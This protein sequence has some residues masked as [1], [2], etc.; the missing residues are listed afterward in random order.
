MLKR[1]FANNMGYWHEKAEK[2]PLVNLP[3]LK[4]TWGSDNAPHVKTHFH[5]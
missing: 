3:I 5:E 1:I 2:S 4:I